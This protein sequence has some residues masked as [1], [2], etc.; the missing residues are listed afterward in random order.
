MQTGEAD[1]FRDAPARCKDGRID[2]SP[3]NLLAKRMTASQSQNRPRTPRT[4]AAELAGPR[5]ASLVPVGLFDRYDVQKLADEAAASD[6]ALRRHPLTA[7]ASARAAVILCGAFDNAVWFDQIARGRKEPERERRF[8]EKL[9]RL[10]KELAE[11]LGVS[12]DDARNPARSLGSDN[13]LA[14]IE[15]LR[16]SV[17]RMTG[18]RPPLP[19]ELDRLCRTAW[20]AAGP[21]EPERDD[22]GEGPALYRKQTSFLIGRF[23]ATLTLVAA[24]ARWRAA[25]LK[26]AAGKRGGKPDRL[27]DELFRMMAGAHEMVFGCRPATRAKTGLPTGGSIAWARAVIR[28]AADRIEASWAGA[29]PQTATAERSSPGQTAMDAAAGAEAAACVARFRALADLSDR[30]VSDLLDQGWKAWQAGAA[31]ELAQRRANPSANGLRDM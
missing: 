17:D 20:S 13:G 15:V 31:Q 30:R 12:A 7:E 9:D 4:R 16:Q 27:R 8:Y 6:P 11:T 24:L 29:K 1:R 10:C 2:L 18:T 14:A 28:W 5:L 23:P 21:E 22:D 19:D 26:R 3:V 25:R